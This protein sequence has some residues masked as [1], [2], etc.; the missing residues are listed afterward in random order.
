MGAAT[1]LD[2][3]VKDSYKIRVRA[4]DRFGGRDF[5]EVT[6]A[7]INV[8]EAGTVSLSS[9]EPQ[10]GTVLTATVTDPDGSVSDVTWSWAKSSDQ[11]AWTDISGGTSATYTPVRGD[12]EN[13]LRATATYIDGEGSGKAAVGGIGQC[14]ACRSAHRRY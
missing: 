8:D 3:E 2:Y 11:S 12:G 4:A 7:V 10:V 9:M 13:Y 6:I 14:G 1:S 5:I